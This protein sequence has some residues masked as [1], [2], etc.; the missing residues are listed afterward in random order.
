MPPAQP[1]A[2]E[3]LTIGKHEAVS[4]EPIGVRWAV[5]HCV[6][7]QRNPDCSHTYGRPTVSSSILV[8][9]VEQQISEVQHCVLIVRHGGS[10]AFSHRCPV[11]INV[12]VFDFLRLHRGTEALWL[13]QLCGERVFL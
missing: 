2:L 3:K 12:A 4:V 8:A 5:P 1:A 6:F 7:E 11:L 9:D 10:P 13:V